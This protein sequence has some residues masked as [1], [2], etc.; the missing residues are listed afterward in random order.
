MLS[1]LC[2][3]AVAALIYFAI[4]FAW[5]GHVGQPAHVFNLH[6]KAW[7]WI[8]AGRFLLRDVDFDISPLALTV[9]LGLFSAGLAAIIPLG[10]GADRL[11]LGSAC[12]STVILAGWTYPLFAHWVWSGGWLAELGHN[13]G[14]GRGF[15]DSGG[16]ST[17]HALG[18]LSALSITWLLGPRRGKYTPAGLP[19]ALPGHHAVFVLFG[20][21]LAWVGWLGLN[22]S[23]AILF[24]AVEITRGPLIAVNTTLAAASAALVAAAITRARFSKTDASLCANGWV[25]GL[26]AASAPCA[27]IR[28]AAAVL[29]GAVAGALVIYSVEW[30]ELHLTIDDPGGAISVHAL[31]GIWSLLAVGLFAQVAEPGQWMAQLVGVAALLGF[32]LPVT[33]GLNWLLDRLYS[34][35][36]APEG[37]RQGMDL[38]EL[39]AG[40]Y[41][42]FMMHN[43]DIW[44]R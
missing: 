42:D 7:N 29:I 35:R 4:G 13:F 8:G 15:L 1:S 9:L 16:A 44:Q 19:V 2:V 6:G 26:V 5:Q 43:E 22:C 10:S 23:A 12:A 28:P 38:H 39:G 14:L 20:C 41:P 25:G 18:G 36:V 27:F 11:R 17:I 33:Y 37:E 30:L 32:G 3:I 40:A 24:S 31:S 34:L 21:F